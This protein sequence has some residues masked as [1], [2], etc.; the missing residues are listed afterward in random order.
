MAQIFQ[1]QLRLVIQLVLVALLLA[2]T[3]LAVIWRLN[4]EPRPGIEMAVEQVVPFSHK[5]HVGDDGL[6]CRY[7]HTTVETSRFAGIPATSTCLTCHSQL[8]RDAPVLAPV[9]ASLRD[10]RPLAWTRVHQLPDF[11]YFDHSIHVAK[12]VGCTTCHGPV[13][14]MPLTWRVAPLTMQWCLECHRA[15]EKFV[16]PRERVF[17]TTW[18]PG[19]DQVAQGKKLVDAYHIRTGQLTDC[20]VCHR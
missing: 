18:Q 15:P 7:C 13:E 20:S 5:H 8:F 9:F 12:G 4:M 2:L 1:P 6:D 11:V 17:D 19:E 14:R 10:D 16:R 3:V